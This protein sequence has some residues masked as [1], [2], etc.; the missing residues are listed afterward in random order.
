MLY[1]EDATAN[2][3]KYGEKSD[4][5]LKYQQRLQK[6]GY[7]TTTP[8]GTYGKDTVSAV[9]RFQELNGLIADGFLGYNTIKTLN[10]SSAQANAL[11]AGHGGQRRH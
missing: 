6:L 4:E 5:I 9:K 3:H 10:S 7:L 8:D 1:S 2:F 11:Q